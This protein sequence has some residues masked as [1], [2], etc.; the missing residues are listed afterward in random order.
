M[1]VAECTGLSV[2][3]SAGSAA[4]HEVTLVESA[5]GAQCIDEPRSDPENI[6]R[7]IYATNPIKAMHRQFRKRTKTKS[8]FPNLLRRGYTW[9]SSMPA[10]S[11]PCRS[12][13]EISPCRNWQSSLSEKI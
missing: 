4:P 11:K 5:L 1:A 8:G 2:A 13:T 6:L 10:R 3:V 9:A 12:R 7:T